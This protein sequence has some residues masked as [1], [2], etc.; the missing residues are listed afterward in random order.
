MASL[1]GTFAVPNV[2]LPPFSVS[3][4]KTFVRAQLELEERHLDNRHPQRPTTPIQSPFVSPVNSPQVTPRTRRR[5][6]VRENNPPESPRR[7]RVPQ[8][9]PQCVPPRVPRAP[10]R[11]R[12]IPPPRQRHPR[13]NVAR[14]PLDPNAGD[15]VHSLQG[16]FN[17][18]YVQVF[19][20]IS[21][22]RCP[23]CGAI[24][25][26]EER[27]PKSTAT[28]LK[29]RCCYD[30]KIELPLINDTPQE[31]RTLLS[32]TYV[33]RNGET[34]FTQRT[35]EFQRLIRAYNNAVAFT[36]LGT[37]IDNRITN[38]THNVYS[39]RIQG[40]MYHHLGA[41]VPPDNERVQYAQ[42]Y[43][44]D[45]DEMIQAQQG[46]F[47]GLQRDILD[48]LNN[49]LRQHNPYVTSFKMAYQR[50]AENPDLRLHLRMIDT[51]AHDPRRYNR[52]ISNE[53]AG[54]I[55]GDENSPE[56]RA[57]RDIVIEHQRNGFQRVS[58]LNPSYFPLRY[59]FMF[60]Y[61]EQGWHAYIPLS[62]IDI[63]ANPELLAWRRNNLDADLDDNEFDDG[64]DDGDGEPRCGKGGSRR[65]SQAQFYNYQ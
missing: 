64:D 9:V 56:R 25:W 37:N 65:V 5:A 49:L 39:L 38:N 55:V 58:E 1:S 33:N 51:R 8:R 42:V 32:E 16:S 43:I 60:L 52:P 29:F 46:N 34:V 63:E 11:Q 3:S 53:I 10:A 27:T 18:A 7:R 59:P 41:L 21:N 30:G 28:D 35:Q 2:I 48:L 62:R 22:F 26:I 12:H 57:A 19:L 24:H 36:S 20:L 23:R 14:Q 45:G 50:I 4:L 61:G 47:T 40:E 17:V 31:L 15:V 54:M 44:Y 13:R 6:A